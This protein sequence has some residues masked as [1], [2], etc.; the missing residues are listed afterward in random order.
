MDC[1]E[2]DAILLSRVGKTRVK[3]I[4][5]PGFDALLEGRK[6]QSVLELAGMAF[7]HILSRS[8][9]H[10]T[11][12]QVTLSDISSAIPLLNLNVQ[13][14]QHLMEPKNVQVSRPAV[15]PPTTSTFGRLWLESK[16][17]PCRRRA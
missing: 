6:I 8:D 1:R 13:Q 10:A 17:I 12:A 4:H 7:G 16:R 3:I 2:T 11:T 15:S 9:R 5:S 14:N